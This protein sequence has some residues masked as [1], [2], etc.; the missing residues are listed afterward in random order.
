MRV[1]G[2]AT[3]PPVAVVFH[4]D[5]CGECLQS[6]RVFRQNRRVRYNPDFVLDD[7]AEQRRIVDE[8]PWATLISSTSTGLVASHLP[9]LLEPEAGD[10]AITI[11]SHLGRPDEHHH[12]L[13]DHRVLVIVQGPSGYVSPTWYGDIGPTVPTWNFIT[14]HLHGTPHLLTAEQTYTVLGRTVDR[15]ERDQPNPFVMSSV[16]DYARKIAPGTLGFSL[17]ADR[18]EAKAKLSQDKPPAALARVLAEFD[19]S[20]PA[21]AREMRR[22]DSDRRGD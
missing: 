13:G 12:E 1:P 5:E 4:N 18:I 7:V 21:L 17:R 19:R 3:D 15:L 2:S 9:V 16:E 20:G 14:V 10:G 8:Y 22:A 6:G 11:T